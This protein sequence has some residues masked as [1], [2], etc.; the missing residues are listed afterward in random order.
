MTPGGPDRRRAPQPSVDSRSI[1]A[2]RAP[3]IP[4]I[5]PTSVLRT[6][7]EIQSRDLIDAL[8]GLIQRANVRVLGIRNDL[9]V[10]ML[11]RARSMP[12][13]PIPDAMIVA[14]A[15]AADAVP[16]ATFDRDQARYGIAVREP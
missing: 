2:T 15:M 3:E 10:A 14:A 12:G 13:R 7:Y 1:W 5:S 9:L 4:R 16:L 6:Q 8:I 11:V